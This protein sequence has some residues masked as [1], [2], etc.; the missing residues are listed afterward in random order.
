MESQQQL[1][2]TITYRVQETD[3]N[4][5]REI[6][7]INLPDLRRQL[8]LRVC[9]AGSDQVLIQDG[10]FL[11]NN[12]EYT[13][14]TLLWLPKISQ[15]ITIYVD[16][17]CIGIYK[18]ILNE[19]DI[20]L[21]I[22]SEIHRQDRLFN[23]KNLNLYK[24]KHDHP[25]RSQAL[26]KLNKPLQYHDITENTVI[27][28]VTLVE[29]RISGYD[30]SDRN[31]I[32]KSRIKTTD[33]IGDFVKIIKDSGYCG[34]DIYQKNQSEKL[35]LTK[36]FHYYGCFEI[37][38]SY[39]FFA[40]PTVRPKTVFNLPK[41]DPESEMEI[42]IKTLTGTTITV[43]IEPMWT[44]EMVKLKIEMKS[45]IPTEQQRLIF[46][47]KQ[48]EDER[49]VS[50]YNIQKESTLHMVLKLTGG[51]PIITFHNAPTIPILVHLKLDEKLWKFSNIYPDT[52]LRNNQAIQWDITPTGSP[53]N[54]ITVNSKIYPYLFW[55]SNTVDEAANQYFIKLR[56]QSHYVLPSADMANELDQGLAIIGLDAKER[57]DMITY[58]MK[59]FGDDHIEFSFIPIS[60]ME[61][62]AP[63]TCVEQPHTTIRVF[64]VFSQIKCP[65]FMRYTKPD[66]NYIKYNCTMIDNKSNYP[67]FK[68][69]EW[70]GMFIKE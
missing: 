4:K 40:K 70:G 58:W 3:S 1:P 21:N 6:S 27:Y 22:F 13:N 10:K 11:E 47:G 67:D 57:T 44:I 15:H 37:D 53:D 60:I 7:A 5:T 19:K 14:N 66:W 59:D 61:E 56:D 31:K 28:G 32:G 54:T 45:G 38:K 55:E 69:V 65:N 23:F 12:D 51:K 68:V 24:Y 41:I 20:I 25:S 8:A 18:L 33:T 62:I 46:A 49:T 52:T 16:I 30:S 35:D 9:G 48:L 50:D 17:Y 36:T 34:F 26:L 42:F 64:M 39:R 63:L 2:T 29:I 43:E